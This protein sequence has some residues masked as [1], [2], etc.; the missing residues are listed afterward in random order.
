MAADPDCGTKWLP[1]YVRVVDELPMTASHKVARRDLRRAW[2]C[3]PGTLERTDADLVPV[4]P[5]ALRS[6]FAAAGRAHL[7]D[8]A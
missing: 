7:L 5:D 3:T 8:L 2:Y 4:D 1:R 6:R